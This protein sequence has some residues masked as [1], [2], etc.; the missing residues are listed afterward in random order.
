MSLP[1]EKKALHVPDLEE[2]ATVLEDGLKSYFASVS[3]SVVDC[4]DLSQQPFTLAA[5]G[6]CG[7]SRAVDVGGIPNIHPLPKL[8]KIYDM[9]KV[10]ELADLP[11]AFMI[12]AGAGPYKHV[13][14]NSELMPNLVASTAAKEGS[15][16]THDIR[17]D[18]D[19]G[20]PILEKCSS[21]ECALMVNLYCSEGKPGKVLE[22]KASKRTGEADFV[23][24]MR[25]VMNERYGEKPVGL[26]GS[27]MIEQ[28]KAWL[29]IMPDF[30]PTPITSIKENEEWLKF[31]EFDA[32]IICLS[33]FYSHDP[34]LDL[35]IE[36]T[37]CF[38][39]HGAGGHYH[40]DTTPDDVVYRGYFHPAEWVYRVDR[41]TEKWVPTDK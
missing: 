37:H 36:H 26:G 17:L 41:P 21:T 28:G 23:A 35:R 24:A 2:L 15:N 9:E 22:V 1:V 40:Y 38:S 25:E 12:G 4:P 7:S 16:C 8:D 34:G 33:V 5:P 10:A 18:V 29:H 19:S 6:L 14:V 3:V 11:G 20:Q 27:F 39:H 13:G 32:P 30:C 31:I